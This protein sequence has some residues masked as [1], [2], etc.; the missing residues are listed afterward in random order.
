M[1]FFFSDKGYELKSKML[2]SI[3]GVFKNMY[4]KNKKTGSKSKVSHMPKIL[5]LTNKITTS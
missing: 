4:E 1:S 3:F 5:K 2:V